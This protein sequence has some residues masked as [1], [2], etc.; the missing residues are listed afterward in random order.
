MQNI[1]K[2]SKPFFSTQKGAHTQF[3]LFF[4]SDI[5]LSSY[6][7]PKPLF[8]PTRGFC[9]PTH[10]FCGLTRDFRDGPRF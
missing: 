7:C 10:G 6:L 1:P 5:W 2:I 8:G 4:L 3:S 9:G